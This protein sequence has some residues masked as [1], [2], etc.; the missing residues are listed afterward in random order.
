MIGNH[1]IGLRGTGA[2]YSEFSKAVPPSTSK[3]RIGPRGSDSRVFAPSADEGA[4]TAMAS[5]VFTPGTHSVRSRL[6]ALCISSSSAAC[7]H[8][9]RAPANFRATLS[10]TPPPRQERCVTV[11]NSG[12]GL[13]RGCVRMH[14]T[15]LHEPDSGTQMRDAGRTRPDPNTTAIRSRPGAHAEVLW[16]SDSVWA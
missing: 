7:P 2:A 4:D 15:P 10:S 14:A 8:L 5:A 3:T 11:H 16:R 13:R 9:H 12:A 6:T 1:I